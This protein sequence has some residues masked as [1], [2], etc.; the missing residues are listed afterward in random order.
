MP[1]HEVRTQSI[2]PSVHARGMLVGTR[3]T[4]CHH[5]SSHP[6]KPCKPPKPEGSP[7]AHRQLKAER[8]GRQDWEQDHKSWEQGSRA[9]T[10]G[11][12]YGYL[13]SEKDLATLDPGK[14]ALKWELRPHDMVTNDANLLISQVDRAEVCAALGLEC[15]V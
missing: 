14:K 10:V 2:S 7:S 12:L 9:H 3:P 5:S 4:L 13:A 11:P 15:R 8:R 1:E 6:T